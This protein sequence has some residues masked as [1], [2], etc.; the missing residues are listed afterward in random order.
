M[1]QHHTIKESELQENKDDTIQEALTLSFNPDKLK[2]YYDQ[3]AINYDEDVSKEQYEGTEYI[4]DYFSQL[5]TQKHKGNVSSPSILDAGCGTG[6][7]G[8]ALR[9]KGYDRIDGCDLSDQMIEEAKKRGAYHALTAGVDLNGMTAIQDGQYDVTISCGV[10]TGG[11][12]PPTALE[13][14][15]RVTKKGGLVMLSTRKSYYNETNF[16]EV[17]DGLARE[18]KLNLFSQTVGP[19]IAEEDAHYWAFEVC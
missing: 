16:Q 6:L 17:C 15:I 13:E 9:Q 3:W 14:L 7:V 10:F 12:V 8:L 5:Y 19:Y 1:S 4:V 11:H 2:T 18:G